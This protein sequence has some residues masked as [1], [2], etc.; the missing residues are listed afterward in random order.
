MSAADLPGAVM[1]H[2]LTE[3]P[4]VLARFVARFPEHVAALRAA[5]PE[6]PA[7]VAFLARGSSDNAAVLGR[8]AVE[9][10]AGVPSDSQSGRTPEIVTVTERLRRA[11][12]GSLLNA[13]RQALCGSDAA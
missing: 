13:L 9:V 6:R 2:E 7:G 12:P 8:Y 1:R 11:G 4:A 3:Q 5:L 10:A